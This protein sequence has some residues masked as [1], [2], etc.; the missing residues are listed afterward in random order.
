MVEGKLTIAGKTRPNS[1]GKRFF[2]NFP[3]LDVILRQNNAKL[4]NLTKIHRSS[5]TVLWIKMLIFKI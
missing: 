1:L 4:R 3:K 5:I 2:A